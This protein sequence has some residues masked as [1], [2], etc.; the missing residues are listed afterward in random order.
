[1]LTRIPLIFVILL[2]I[3]SCKKVFVKLKQAEIHVT[4]NAGH[5]GM[6]AGSPTAISNA[7]ANQKI[8]RIASAAD[9]DSLITYIEAGNYNLYPKVNGIRPSIRFAGIDYEK[10]NL[11]VIFLGYEGQE[12]GEIKREKVKVKESTKELKFK[13]K[14]SVPAGGSGMGKFQKLVF[15]EVPID[16]CNYNISG[17]VVVDEYNVI[18]G[19][20][21]YTVDYGL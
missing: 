4:D 8:L 12:G 9:F 14:L 3:T 11:F 1:M 17:S 18:S 6:G 10:S 19:G 20:K 5:L 21:D 16:K 2:S 7:F 15:F 13:M